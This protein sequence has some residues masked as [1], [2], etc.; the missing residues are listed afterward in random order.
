MKTSDNN[1]RLSLSNKNNK[2]KETKAK[3][4]SFYILSKKNTPDNNQITNG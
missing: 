1:G 4:N 2:S 3:H